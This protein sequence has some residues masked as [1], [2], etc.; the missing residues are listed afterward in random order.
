MEMA[1]AAGALRIEI[2]VRQMWCDALWRT[3]DHARARAEVGGVTSEA[4]RRH[5]RQVASL[6]ELQAACWAVEEEDWLA[7]R[8]HRDNAA[9]HGAATG[10]LPERAHLSGLDLALALSADD[11]K[12]IDCAVDSLVREGKGYGEKSF[13]ELLKKIEDLSPPE[14]KAR[15]REI[16]AS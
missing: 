4:D 10:A 1:R 11:S 3:G 16:S 2:M 6:A 5:L 13:R 14:L 15:L 7:A 8:E 12:A 9:A